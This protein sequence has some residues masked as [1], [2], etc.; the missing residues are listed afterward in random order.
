MHDLSEELRALPEEAARAP[1]LAQAVLLEQ[2]QLFSVRRELLVL[3][4]AAVAVL[5][6]GVGL[7][8]KANL[9]RIGPLALLGGNLA[10]AAGCYAVAL[11]VRQVRRPRSLGEDYVLLL[12]ALLF[13]TAVGFAETQFHVLGAG[14]SR[15]LL[16]LALWHLVT[17]YLFRS[18]LVLAVSLTAFAGWLGVEARLGTWFDP[19]HPLLGLGPRGL[20][21][22]T[23]FYVGGWFHRHEQA[24]T[25]TGFRDV[26][27]QFAANFGFWG[28][29]ALGASS[30]T[31][32]LGALLLIVLALIIAR[33]GLTERRQS[34]LLYAVG[35]SA[36]GLIWLESLLL[37]DWLVMSWAG[38]LTVVG[39][40][41]LL[42]NLRGRLQHAAG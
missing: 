24:G 35:Y 27:R 7:L 29:L 23:L 33:A 12:G 1:A 26:Y 34:F 4:Y 9:E 36:V 10:A 14:W 32:W 15:H 39:A 38:L 6:S 8:I 40:I 3:I 19:L 21:C 42:M 13:S 11:R 28:A 18:R 2:R 22:A 37:R 17:A 25:A 30:D 41:V 5:V 20:L 31:R 16:L